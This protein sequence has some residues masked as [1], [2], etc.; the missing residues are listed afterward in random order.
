MGDIVHV[1]S[2]QFPEPRITIVYDVDPAAAASQRKSQFA[3]LA[4]E[5]RLVAA[6]HLPFPGIGHIRAEA[7]GYTWVPVDYIN[8]DVR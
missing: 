3:T 4:S 2:V 5:R 8:R 7:G 1:A 6:A